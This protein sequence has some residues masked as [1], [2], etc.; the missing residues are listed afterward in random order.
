MFS[1][2]Y[3]FIYLKEISILEI[4]EEKKPKTAN[5]AHD[6]LQKVYCDNLA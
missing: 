2:F 6:I 4:K 5:N 1:N 3:L